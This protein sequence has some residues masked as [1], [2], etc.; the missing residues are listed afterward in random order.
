M[1]RLARGRRSPS[2]QSSFPVPPPPQVPS[3]LWFAF[4][5]AAGLSVPRVQG[6]AV[7]GAV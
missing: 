7:T 5:L 2:F 6:T 1:F 3:G 4:D